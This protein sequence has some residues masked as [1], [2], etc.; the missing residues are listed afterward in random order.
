MSR[1]NSLTKKELLT[2]LNT[3]IAYI[4]IILF[5]VVSNWLFISQ[6]FI[7]K[8]ASMRGYFAYMPWILL[9]IIPAIS[10][11][12]WSEEYK[13]G[14]IEFLLTLPI[15]DWQATL[16]KFFSSTILLCVILIASLTIPF[17][18]GALGNTD[19]G[20]IIGGY[21]A[22]LLYGLCL[23]A[24]GQWISSMCKNQ[25]IAFMVA[26]FASFGLLIIGNGYVLVSTKGLLMNILQNSSTIYHY[27]NIARG[28]IDIRDVA[29][30]VSAIFL[31]L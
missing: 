6:F 24:I 8:E 13:S 9:F 22:T 2:T 28:V 14:T 1:I 5:T 20:E 29:Y 31:A 27:F 7:T 30:F 26:M 15:S 18:V 17:T 21:T 10:M 12:T 19:A 3:P 23:L 25:I 16:A 11:R 4:T